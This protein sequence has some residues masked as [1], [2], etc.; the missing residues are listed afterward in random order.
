ML[1]GTLYSNDRL[2][3]FTIRVLVAASELGISLDV[4]YGSEIPQEVRA[5]NSAGKWPLFWERD[6]SPL[7]D[8]AKIVERLIEAAGARGESYRCDA[9]LLRA[10]DGFIEN[11]SPVICA[12]KPE[13]QKERRP[14]LETSLTLMAEHLRKNKGAYLAGST[15]SQAEGHIVAFLHRMAFLGEI[16]AYFPAALRDDPALRDWLDRT[17]TQASFVSVKPSIRALRAFYEKAATYGKAMKIGRLHHSGFRPMWDDLQAR[18]VRLSKDDHDHEEVAEARGLCVLLFRA[19]ALHAKFENLSLFPTLNTS[20]NNQLFTQHGIND[21]EHEVVALNDLLARCNDA[22]KRPAGEARRA[23]FEHAASGF[24]AHRESFFAHLAYEEAHYMPVLAELDLPT[25]IR[26]LKEAY[27]MCLDE[28]PFLIGVVVAY[29]PK[30]NRLSFIDSLSQA[31]EPEHPQWR[32]VMGRIHQQV[33][34]ETW[35]RIV[36]MFEDIL[37]TS[38]KLIPAR[39]QRPTFAAL[40]N[41]LESAFPV[42]RIEIPNI[43]TPQISSHPVS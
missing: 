37:P 42:T 6:A 33:D 23:A 24:I 7:L 39:H 17:T 28:R 27:A 25:H 12:G 38:L 11:L 40:A 31:V 21:H 16:R 5:E 22:A 18:L 36:H 26:L 3:P 19:V 43:A 20:Q 13:I 15:F 4:K 9:G 29:M 30:E 2:C 10:L 34:E 8:S 32:L 1:S 41:E 35:L 14:K